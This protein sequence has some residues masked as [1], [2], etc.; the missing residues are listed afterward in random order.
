MG[1]VSNAEEEKWLASE[2]G[3]NSIA[4]GIYTAFQQYYN[5]K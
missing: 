3:K 1:F 4:N 2:D 5:K